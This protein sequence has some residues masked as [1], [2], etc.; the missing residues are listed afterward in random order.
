MKSR[1]DMLILSQSTSRLVLFAESY[2]FLSCLPLRIRKSTIRDR[3]LSTGWRARMSM[4]GAMPAEAIE[5][6][7]EAGY[8]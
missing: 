2:H 8:Q 1:L 6:P 4:I 5:K 7:A 3:K